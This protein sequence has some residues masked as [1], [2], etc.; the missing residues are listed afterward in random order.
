M[1]PLSIAP[2]ALQDLF[3]GTTER[4][5]ERVQS[6]SLRL[7]QSLRNVAA[8]GEPG[9]GW[10][11][12][13]YAASAFCT[14]MMMISVKLGQQAGFSTW[15]LLMARS[16]FLAIVCVVQLSRTQSDFL[17]LRERYATLSFASSRSRVEVFSG[18]GIVQCLLPGQEQIC[19]SRFTTCTRYCEPVYACVLLQNQAKLMHVCCYR[20]PL[21]LL[22]GI[23]GCTSVTTLFFATKKLPI[24][25]A[26]VF[27]FLAPVIVAVL[28]PFML[29]ESSKGVW[30]SIAGCSVGV[31][32]VAQPGFLF[33]TARLSVLG[34]CLGLIQ[35]TASG[36]AKVSCVNPEV[37]RVVN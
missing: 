19:D 11:L 9:E 7:P 10:G 4:V 25:D 22:R 12:L 20:R 21:L 16:L 14:S 37:S 15:E 26:T 32:L 24:A 2:P 36:T 31:L 1:Q 18:R 17:G 29:K 30:I 23:L 28:S 6:L 33:G 5:G 3:R 13:C 8:Q 34:V 27:S 35:A